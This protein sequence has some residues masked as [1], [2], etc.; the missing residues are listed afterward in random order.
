M[1]VYYVRHG[2]S[3][4]NVAGIAAGGNFETKLTK[5]GCEQAVKAGQELKDKAIDLIV[6]SPMIRTIDTATI[7]ARQLDYDPSN[8]VTSE[9][10]TE[11]DFG[12]FSGRPHKEYRAAVLSG[13]EEGMESAAHLQ[14]RIDEGFKWLKKQGAKTIVLVSH[15]STGRMIRAMNEG[16]HRSK[17]YELEAFGNTE[18][19]E[20]EL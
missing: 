11:R 1:K 2:E 10:F 20:F 8:I 3:E 19:Y 16:I 15:G 5:K 14:T 18:I 12:K 9:F 13:N 6:C 4:A 17:M 7:I